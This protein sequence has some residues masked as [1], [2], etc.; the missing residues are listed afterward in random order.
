MGLLCREREA[1][2]A[3]VSLVAIV[4]SAL[5]ARLVVV[6][7]LLPARGLLRQEPSE[8]AA[9]INAGLGFVYPQYG[10]MY[11]GLK[12]PGHIAL[13]ALITR[14]T[15]DRDLPILVLQWT[16]GAALAVLAAILTRRLTGSDRAGVLAGLLV[17]L[18]PF[19]VY[20]D[21]L[22]VHSLTLD[23]LLF[24]VVAAV[25]LRAADDPARSWRSAILAGLVTGI[26]LW[27]RSLLL[28]GGLGLWAVAI[29]LARG[30]RRRELQRAIVWTVVAV[31]LVVPW[32]ARNHAVI[33]RWVFTTDFAHVLWLGNNPLSNGTYSDAIGARIYYRADPA[34]R[35][36]IE[37]H[38]EVEQMETFLGAVR[39]FVREHPAQEA[40]LIARKA[41]AFVWFA[42][43]VGAE[44]RPWQTVLYI[45]W[46]IA[47]LVVGVAG[48]VRLWRAS[49]ARV[50]RRM[51][52]IG[53]MLLGI[54]ALHA[55]VAINMKHR[56]P[57][58]IVLAGFAG[59]YL[60]RAHDDRTRTDAVR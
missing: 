59:S 7:A 11:Y 33:G 31:T 52:L 58:E 48:A 50:H 40:G 44:Y 27:Q 43:N 4:A 56:V 12:E 13:L 9:N 38:S 6:L 29:A 14:W 60:A 16:C 30:A 53:G 20:Y 2:L 55:A 51:L 1:A 28:F 47:L 36:R 37:G 24:V 25:T 3:I 15:G 46:Y 49:G 41:V 45:A 21:S 32:F 34:F 23:M 57:L 5:A 54:M 35:A 19:L 10:T 22:I 8:I 17:A 18:N 26:A 39:A 42:P